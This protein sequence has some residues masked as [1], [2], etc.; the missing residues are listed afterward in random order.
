MKSREGKAGSLSGAQQTPR[1]PE[2]GQRLGSG[3][4]SNEMLRDLWASITDLSAPSRDSTEKLHT[5]ACQG[6]KCEESTCRGVG[7]IPGSG[8]CPGGGHGHPL[9]S[10]RLENPMDRGAW[11]LQSMGSQ[12][13]GQD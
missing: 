1:G 6:V 3:G 10:S 4:S 13:V 5:R 8:R 11:G 7:L 9:L 2:P 12:R